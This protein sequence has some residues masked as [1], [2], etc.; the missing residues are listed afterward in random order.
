[1]GARDRPEMRKILELK[2]RL[3]ASTRAGHACTR[4]PAAHPGLYCNC[5]RPA[6][7]RLPLYDEA[8][9]DLPHTA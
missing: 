6:H 5:R 3:P 7:R 9:V 2:E 4:K 1:M 8:R